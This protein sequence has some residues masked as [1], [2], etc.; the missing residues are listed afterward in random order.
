[1]Y[2]AAFYRLWYTPASVLLQG[3]WLP[4][5][6]SSWAGAGFPCPWL[7]PPPQTLCISYWTEELRKKLSRVNVTQLGE[8]CWFSVQQNHTQLGLI[9]SNRTEPRYKMWTD[10][11]NKR[12]AARIRSFKFNAEI[13]VNEVF[14]R[15]GRSSSTLRLSL[16]I[17]RQNTKMEGII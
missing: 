4:G 16:W 1:M 14:L 10:A 2:S 11:I 17:E 9:R 15:G 13:L 12:H 5:W 6:W 8:P 3:I 7:A